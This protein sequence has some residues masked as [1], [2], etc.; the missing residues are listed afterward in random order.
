MTEEKITMKSYTKMENKGSSLET[1][2]INIDT[3]SVQNP[4]VVGVEFV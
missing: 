3:D 4:I 1:R 2:I